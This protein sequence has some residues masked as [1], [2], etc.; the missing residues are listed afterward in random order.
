[1][2]WLRMPRLLIVLCVF[3]SVPLSS[4][5]E[6]PVNGKLRCGDLQCEVWESESGGW[7]SPEA[8]W[9]HYAAANEGAF[10]GKTP[11]YPPYEKVAEHDTLLLDTGRGLCLME[12]FHSRWRR[13][14]DVRRWD[15]GFTELGG[16]PY[17]FE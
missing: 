9:L 14:N 8:F 7:L 5:D 1:M 12:F 3:F 16:C 10:W 15:P 2:N 4:A 11:D 13:A 6:M 17:V